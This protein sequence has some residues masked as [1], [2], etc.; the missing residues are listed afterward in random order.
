MFATIEEAWNVPPD[1]TNKSSYNATENLSINSE[2]FQS[3][4]FENKKSIPKFS[5]KSKHKY[6]RKQEYSEYNSDDDEDLLC[7]SSYMHLKKCSNCR[8]KFDKMVDD[9]MND[10]FNMLFF[11]SKL[12]ELKNNSVNLKEILIIIAITLITLFIIYIISSRLRL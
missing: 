12:N 8:N 2:D 7:N 5:T 6:S 10:K 9:K 11:S 4:Y 1:K 3:D